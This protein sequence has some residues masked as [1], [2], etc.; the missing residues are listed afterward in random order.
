M[1]TPTVLQMPAIVRPK[2]ADTHGP[3]EREN[4]AREGTVA[5]DNSKIV[6]TLDEVSTSV[7]L[8]QVVQIDAQQIV[9]TGP[10]IRV[11]GLEDHMAMTPGLTVQQA[12]LLAHALTDAAAQLEAIEALA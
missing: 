2:W 3:L 5:A 7:T 11:L 9:V 8:N 6:R 4:G 12:R 1:F 10:A